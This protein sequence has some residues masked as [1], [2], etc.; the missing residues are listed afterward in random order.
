MARLPSLYQIKMSGETMTNKKELTV[1]LIKMN[2]A[3]AL[4]SMKVTASSEKKPSEPIPIITANARETHKKE[5]YKTIEIILRKNFICIS[6]LSTKSN[7]TLKRN[8]IP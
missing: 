6:L 4:E 8:I 2:I 5:N 7:I 1:N 3:S